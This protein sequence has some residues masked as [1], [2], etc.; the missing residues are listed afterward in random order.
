MSEVL[1]PCPFCSNEDLDI[2]VTDV[3]HIS[4]IYCDEC[5]CEGPIDVTGSNVIPRTKW[6]TRTPSPAVAALVE[7]LEACKLE[8]YCTNNQLLQNGYKEGETLIKALDLASKALS[9][10]KEIQTNE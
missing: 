9:A 6:N 4:Y 2:G 10:F 1:K 8:L 7:A 5:G 3:T